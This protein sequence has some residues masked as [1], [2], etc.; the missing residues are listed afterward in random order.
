MTGRLETSC[1]LMLRFWF[2]SKFRG[3]DEDSPRI[4]LKIG[5]CERIIRSLL[6]KELQCLVKLIER[7]KNILETFSA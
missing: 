4:S 2:L 7:S 5:R 6:R 1:D 3:V